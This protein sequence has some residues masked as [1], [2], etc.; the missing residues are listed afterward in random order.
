MSS[1]L[2]TASLLLTIIPL[3]AVLFWQ[4]L[5]TSYEPYN[6]HRSLRRI[7]GD[8]SLRYLFTNLTPTQL[9]NHFGST[10]HVYGK[11]TKQFKVPAIVDELGVDARLLWIGSKRLEHVVLFVHGGGYFLPPPDFALSFWQHVQIEIAKCGVEAG[12]ALL[13]YSL[14][15]K[16]VFPTPLNQLCQAVRFLIAAGVQPSRIHL[17]GDSAGDNLVIQLLSHLLHPHSDVPNIQL[18]QPFGGIYLLSPWVSL[19]TD[20]Q[21]YTECD[22]IDWIPTNKMAAVGASVQAGFPE[23]DNMYAETVKAPE[24]WFKGVDRLVKR[25][26]ITLGEKEGLRDDVISF[27]VTFKQYHRSAEVVA[28]EGGIHE[29]MFLGFMVAEKKLGTLTPLIIDRLV[30]GCTSD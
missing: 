8:S 23:E 13:N 11:W 29:D 21:S 27:G 1:V 19:T 9:R 25:V 30:T 20:R 12:F 15:P 22:G 5:R 16:G 6:K 18:S 17:A 26:L 10:L 2:Q 28:Q 24:E 7:L 4:V 3:P 14:A